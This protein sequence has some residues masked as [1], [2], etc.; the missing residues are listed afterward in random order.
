MQNEVV[1]AVSCSPDAYTLGGVGLGSGS[2]GKLGR[3]WVGTWVG[4]W[5]V[6]GIIS[7]AIPLGMGQWN[8][9][10]FVKIGAR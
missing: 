2:T 8:Q 3:A 5:V 10:V 4:A 6:H 1:A 7:G 9:N